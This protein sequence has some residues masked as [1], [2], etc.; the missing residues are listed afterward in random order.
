MFTVLNY[1]NSV[2]EKGQV[3]AGELKVKKQHKNNRMETIQ[4]KVFV[5]RRIVMF[6]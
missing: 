2:I 4:E 3:E 1:F 6:I 5:N